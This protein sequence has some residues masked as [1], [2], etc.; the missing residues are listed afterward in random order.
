MARLRIGII[1]TGGM[2]HWQA[3]QFD[4]T[5]CCEI[6]AACDVDRARAGSFA[7][8]YNAPRAYDDYRAMLDAGGLDAIS[9]VTSDDAHYPISMAALDKKLH[10]MCVRESRFASHSGCPRP[11]GICDL[12]G[13]DGAWDG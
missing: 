11:A 3:R 13:H 7:K 12:R 4:E 9:I 6:V 10:V 8:L 5:G 1:G 2:A